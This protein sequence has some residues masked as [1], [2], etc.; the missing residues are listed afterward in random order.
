MKVVIIGGVAAGMTLARRLRRENNKI[1]IIIIDRA[2]HLAPATCMLPY[3]IDE[4]FIE[5]R[6]YLKEIEIFE[7]E[8]NIDIKIMNE[9]IGLDEKNKEIK[10]IETGSGVIYKIKYDKLVIA[11]GTNAIKLK[12]L[13]NL[14]ENIF[15]FKNLRN[16]Q[17]LKDTIYNKGIKDIAIIGAGPLSLELSD[18]LSKQD[19]NITLI[20]REN[21]ILPQYDSNLTDVLQDNIR[22]KINILTNTKV[23]S[24]KLLSND[25]IELNLGLKNI[26]VDLVLVSV[27]NL[28]N[29]SFL[30]NTS[31]KKDKSGYIIVDEYFKT[32]NE[33]IY[34]LGDVILTKE[35]ITDTPMVF[36][37]S[38][39]AQKQARFVSNNILSTMNKKIKTEPYNGA[40]KTEIV[41]I[42]DYT[43]GKVGLTEN[44][45]RNYYMP[46]GN[47]VTIG[48][49]VELIYIKE[50]ANN[51]YFNKENL[52]Y[53]VGFFDK[54][55]KRLLGVQAL[56]KIGVDKRL[57]V[58]ATAIKA[59]MTAQDLI[60]LDLTYSPPYNIP[61]DI[62]NRLGS[63]AV[64]GE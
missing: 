19:L 34:A 17:R 24:S 33:D 61:R 35:H 51:P 6:L 22:K 40:V 59:N 1:E 58:A 56:G 18:E 60:N 16:L 32:N 52:I 4:D 53:L 27:G 7:K 54:K 64:K 39:I 36:G 25:K 2:Y 3:A 49:D 10:V 50:L 20:D 28:P 29:V 14:N 63:L 15:I 38:S 62:I 5:D 30:D 43:L 9:V 47:H 31:I 26:L 12:E 21:K 8:F 45:I 41:K 46:N 13:D 11:T 23:L 57:D 55:T 44:D 37:T 42:F 48:D